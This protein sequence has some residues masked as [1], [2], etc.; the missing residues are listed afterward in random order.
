[1]KLHLPA[2]THAMEDNDDTGLVLRT[3]IYIGI[4]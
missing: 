3:L 2:Y 1:M 4:V